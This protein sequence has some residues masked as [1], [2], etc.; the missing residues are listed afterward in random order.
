MR[1]LPCASCFNLELI[2]QLPA[3]EKVFLE[4]AEEKYCREKKKQTSS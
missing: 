1:F 2:K 4:V 3:T